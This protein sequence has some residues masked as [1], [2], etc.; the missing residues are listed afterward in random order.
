MYKVIHE[1]HNVSCG[2]SEHGAINKKVLGGKR[3]EG[4][5]RREEGEGAGFS[6]AY[7]LGSSPI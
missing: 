3:E 1:E 4:G 5:R 7:S 2:L 6:D